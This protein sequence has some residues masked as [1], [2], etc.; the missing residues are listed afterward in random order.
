MNTP[1]TGF[2]ALGR[3]AVERVPGAGAGK[4]VAADRALFVLLQ[5]SPGESSQLKPSDIA[6]YGKDLFG[7]EQPMATKVYQP[8]GGKAFSFDWKSSKI[9]RRERPLSKHDVVDAKGFSFRKNVWGAAG[10]SP[11]RV[12]IAVVERY[13]MLRIGTGDLHEVGRP[14]RRERTAAAAKTYTRFVQ[15]REYVGRVREIDWAARTFTALLNDRRANAGDE[16]VASFDVRM[17]DGQPRDQ[18]Y[19]GAIFTLVTGYRQTVSASGKILDTRLDSRLLLTTAPELSAERRTETD[20]VA[21]RL[22][23]AG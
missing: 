4:G 17:A 1:I 19:V 13:G 3:F 18:F 11:Q 20:A 7:R 12:A 22:Y 5:G 14:A 8:L 15:A 21:D 6:L 16:L 10:E 2:R 9:G 23:N